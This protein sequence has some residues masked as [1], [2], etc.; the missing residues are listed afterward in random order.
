MVVKSVKP[1]EV[2][3]GYVKRKGDKVEGGYVRRRPNEV[4]EVHVQHEGGQVQKQVIRRKV[5]QA[6]VNKPLTKEVRISRM[7]LVVDLR[8]ACP[9]LFFIA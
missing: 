1:D 6:P 7:L 4:E 3:E 5:E 9:Y 2:Q 8:R